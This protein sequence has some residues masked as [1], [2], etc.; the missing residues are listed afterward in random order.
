MNDLMVGGLVIGLCLC[1]CLLV[2]AVIGAAAY[3][4]WK[5]SK[6]EPTLK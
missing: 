4:I 3:W 5:N 6:K 1:G 2:V